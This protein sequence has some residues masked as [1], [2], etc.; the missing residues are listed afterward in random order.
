MRVERG[1]TGEQTGLQVHELQYGIGR[2]FNEIYAHRAELPV[3][4]PA[5]LFRTGNE[6]L[7][8]TFFG[9]APDTGSSSLSCVVQV[10][11]ARFNDVVHF[12]PTHL[13]LL[14]AFEWHLPGLPVS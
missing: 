3:A 12:R 8:A 5:D 7:P 13:N 4:V 9:P 6:R 1:Q 2:A 10:A 11:V 14:S